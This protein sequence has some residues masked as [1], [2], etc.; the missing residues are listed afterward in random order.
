MKNKFLI[1]MAL[2]AILLVA[3]A[4]AGIFDRFISSKAKTAAVQATA[5]ASGSSATGDSAPGGD[6]IPGPSRE[7]RT[8]VPPT[9]PIDMGNA[10]YSVTSTLGHAIIAV[11]NGSRDEIPRYAIYARSLNGPAIL[12]ETIGEGGASDD[13]RHYTAVKGVSFAGAG[14][15]GSSIRNWGVAGLSTDHVGVYGQTTN[16]LQYSGQFMGGKGIFSS[17]GYSTQDASNA[18]VAG[19]TGSFRTADGKT[20]TVT[21]G[22][23][24]R[25]A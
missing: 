2:F 4:S 7:S 5:P 6:S 22:I 8:D 16:E 14:V 21:K 9:N 3:T 13:T 23:I 10:G 12:G 24:T 18:E 1:I 20:V 11:F 19:A 17:K 15:R 25:I